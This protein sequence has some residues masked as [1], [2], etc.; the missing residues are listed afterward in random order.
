MIL[1]E[2]N[3]VKDVFSDKETFKKIFISFIELK[4]GKSV[5]G[6]S[7]Y[8]KYTVLGDLIVGY[9]MHEWKKT[10]ESWASSI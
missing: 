1:N 3:L 6:S 2:N 4:F 5:E 10:R 7:V 8:E 9:T